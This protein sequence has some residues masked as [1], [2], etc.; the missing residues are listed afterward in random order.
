[1]E[2]F[3]TVAVILGVIALG[4]LLIHRLNSQHDE[5]IADFHYGRS[6]LPVAGPA[7]SAPPKARDGAG[8]SGTARRDHRHGGRRRLRPWL[9]PRRRTREGAR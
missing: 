6:G 5:R 2:T 4:V 3:V 7:P 9:R 1:M 8:T